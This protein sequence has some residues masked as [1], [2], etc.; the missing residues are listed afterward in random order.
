MSDQK[1]LNTSAISKAY[2]S[3]VQ[4]EKFKH[5][6][7]SRL[8]DIESSQRQENIL[9]AM[10]TIRSTLRDLL[11]IDFGK[12][13]HLKLV[14]DDW[15][16]WARLSLRLE[17]NIEDEQDTPNF[18][19]RVSDHNALGTLE[20]I[21]NGD[22]RTLAM[23][24]SGVLTQV[25]GFLRK[26]LRDYLDLV[27]AFVIKNEKALKGT[28]KIELHDEKNNEENKIDLEYQL[29]DTASSLNTLP[30]INDLEKLSGLD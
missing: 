2:T 22:L 27:T 30:I 1:N 17:D 18:C 16:G 24:N 15:W 11:S 12:R 29:E 19:V 6:R 25:P 28:Q 26:I 21:I 23:T 13:Y 5:Q 4:K 8:V 9:L 14:E 10:V 3:R 7:E 20:F